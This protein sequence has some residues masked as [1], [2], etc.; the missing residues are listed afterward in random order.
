MKFLAK[1]KC[2]FK[3]LFLQRNDKLSFVLPL[4]LTGTG[5][6]GSD[7]E[8]AKILLDSCVKFVDPNFIDVFLIVCPEKDIEVIRR[9]LQKYQNFFDLIFMCEEIV[10]PVLSSDPNTE[11]AW[12]KPNKGWYRQQ[13]IKLAIY[14]YINTDF[15]MTLDSD[16]IFK[17]NFDYDDAFTYGKAIVNTETYKDYLEIYNLDVAD[18]SQEVRRGRYNDAERILK[19]T[20]LGS[21][22]QTWYGETPVMLSRNIVKNLVAY[23]ERV[24]E[25]SWQDVLL[26]NFPWTEYPIYFVYAET[27]GLFAKYHLPGGADSISSLSQ[28]L[29]HDSS[30]YLD[31]RMLSNWHVNQVF[32]SASVGYCVVVQSYLGYEPADIRC[33]IEHYIN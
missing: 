4:A 14:K 22:R 10:C 27:S 8:R 15:Y 13:L 29:W 24:W 20:D 30:S 18:E 21:S 16:V 17:K 1:L 33:K 6:A 26:L 12:P 31:G 19:L 32:H 9:G 7:L 23:I 2:F 3:K 11:H 28:S 5:R 25:M